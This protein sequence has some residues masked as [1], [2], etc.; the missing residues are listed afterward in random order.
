MQY[1][2]ADISKGYW[3]TVAFDNSNR[4][5]VFRFKTIEE[6]WKKYSAA[7]LILIDIPIGLLDDGTAWRSCD[8]EAR[9]YLEAKKNSVFMVPCR[10]AIYNTSHTEASSLNKQITGKGLSIQTCC[11]IPKIRE[12]DDFL[13]SN[14]KARKKI[15]EIHPELCFW[16]LN[17]KTPMKFKK[18]DKPGFEER[19]KL[20]SSLHPLCE[21]VLEYSIIKYSRK[22]V[23][24][25]DI[26]DALVAV[27]TASKIDLGLLMIPT[28]PEIDSNGLP[29]QMIYHIPSRARN[30]KAR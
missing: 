25:D 3:F 5:E 27:I 6:L 29:M 14:P 13:S 24:K 12:T 10:Q 16:A 28:N 26:L 22:E 8:R 1:I 23:A 9:Q 20:L 30:E 17:N 4:F 18:N 2:G 19:Y 15:Q 7:K 21:A 11:I